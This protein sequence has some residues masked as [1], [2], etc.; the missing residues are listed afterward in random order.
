VWDE[1]EDEDDDDDDDDDD[2]ES[3][4]EVSAACFDSEG[5]DRRPEQGQS[6]R[7]GSR[8]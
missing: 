8:K 3:I 5:S 2:D 6:C 1:D 7:H 4:P